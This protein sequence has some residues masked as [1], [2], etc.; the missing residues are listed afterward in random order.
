VVALSTIVALDRS[1]EGLAD[2][3]RGWIARRDAAFS[4]W[5]RFKHE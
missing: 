5:Q 4:P 2:L 3:P 1:V